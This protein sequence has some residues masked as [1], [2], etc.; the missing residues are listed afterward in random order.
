VE[1]AELE[2]IVAAANRLRAR[3]GDQD[4]AWAAL[5]DRLT[6]KSTPL[7]NSLAAAAAVEA[8]LGHPGHRLA[9]YGTLRP[10]E[11]NHRLLAG[12]GS[13]RAGWVRGTLGDWCGYPILEP[14]TD[15]V[16]VMVLNSARLRDRLA[17]LDEFEGP[18]YRRAWVVVE[19]DPALAGD[20]LV[21]AQC[22]LAAAA[23]LSG[24]DSRFPPNGT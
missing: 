6:G 1:R 2:E 17:A 15:R 14:G 22:Y 5:G 7:R 21:V 18:A 24:D 3:S 12:L 23:P 11:V 20:E 13:W 9:T 10:G 4:P 16:P 8:L 19:H